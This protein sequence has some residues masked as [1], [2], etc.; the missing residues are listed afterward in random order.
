MSTNTSQNH[1]PFHPVVINPWPNNRY[2]PA[3]HA[4]DNRANG[5]A[6]SPVVRMGTLFFS[7]WMPRGP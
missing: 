6:L 5:N 7:D 3:E 1:W 4:N 2:G